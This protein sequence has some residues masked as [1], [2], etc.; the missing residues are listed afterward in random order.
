MKNLIKYLKPYMKESILSPFFKLL[1]VAFDLMVPVVVAKMIDTG[2]AQ[3]DYT[4]IFRCAAILLAMALLGLLCSVTAQFFAAR[5]SAG[6]GASLRQTMFDHIQ[7]FSFSMLDRAG[8]DTL[9][10]R[11]NDDVNQVQNGVNMCLRL[12]LRSPFIVFGATAVAFTVNVKCAVIF[13]VTVPVLFAVIFAIMLVSIPLFK[14]VQAGLDRITELT[15]ENITGVRVIRAFGREKYAAGE[16]EDSNREL[17]RLNEFVGKISAVLNPLTYAMINIAAVILIDKAAI[18]VN[19]GNLQQGETVALYNYMMQIIVELIKL[20]ALIITLNKSVA[21]A[22]RISE[23]LDMKPDMEYP[24]ADTVSY[25]AGNPAVEFADVTFSYENAAAPSL[26]NI[27][28][29]VES[30]QTAGIIGGTGS[31]KTTL[32]N[33]IARFYDATE[34]KVLIDGTDIKNYSKETLEKRCGIVQQKT[35]LF[36]GSIRDNLRWGNEK[37]DDEKLWKALETAQAKDVAAG[38]PGQLDFELERGGGNLSG[39]QRQRISIARTLVKEPEI[40]IFDDSFS[41]LDFATEAALRK[42]LHNMERQ[43]AVF[44]VSQRISAIRNSDIIIVLDNGVMAGKGSHEELMNSCET[45]R[46]IYYSQFPEERCAK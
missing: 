35:V 8:S 20:A 2:V 6:F 31:G 44:I 30:G 13:A 17:T 7:K 45:Y 29:A 39:G 11:I 24:E 27:S 34:G 10:T 22:G 43:A 9:I 28:F 3:Q 12:I 5:A 15:R 4:F 37:A 25:E 18:E 26:K 42:A 19:L 23:V 33:L 46:E 21:C 16:F 1:E 32:V 36:K 41:A 14:K 40:L 38:K